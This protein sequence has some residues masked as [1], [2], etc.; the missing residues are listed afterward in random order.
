MTT[1]N[2]R[3]LQH[4]MDYGSINPKIALEW[5][6]VMRL[7]ARIYDLKK[8]GYD[9]ETVSTKS[10]NRF[11]EPVRFAAYRLKEQKGVG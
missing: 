10:K 6:G 2:D 7:G 4:M 11:G 8:Q 1:Q 5:Y 9:I 3:I